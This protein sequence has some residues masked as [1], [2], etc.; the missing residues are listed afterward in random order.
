MCG[1]LGTARS[2]LVRS[3]RIRQHYTIDSIYEGS[4][5]VYTET[6]RIK[7]KLNIIDL[8][9]YFKNNTND[10]KHFLSVIYS[11]LLKRFGIKSDK[12]NKLISLIYLA[13]LY[14]YYDSILAENNLPRKSDFVDLE[15]AVYLDCCDYIL[16][17]DGNYRSLINDCPFI[18]LY[19][20][21]I[22]LDEF[23]EKIESR[24]FAMLKRAPY[25]IKNI[26]Y[27]NNV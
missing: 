17:N 2:N 1:A 8:V 10:R 3:G 27:E 18:D 5:R 20:R 24:E 7:E 21:A 12:D 4:M 25:N 6:K 15:Q 23:I 16:T 19:G 9:D 11:N 22:C 13:N 14:I 26:K